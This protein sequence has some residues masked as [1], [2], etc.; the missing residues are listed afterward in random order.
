MRA[1]FL[2]HDREIVD[3]L[4]EAEVDRERC[5]QPSLKTIF[6]RHEYLVCED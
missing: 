2:D 5:M 3:R 4:I 1:A 6:M